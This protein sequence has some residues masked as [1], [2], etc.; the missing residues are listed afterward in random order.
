MKTDGVVNSATL[1]CELS[2][3]LTFVAASTGFEAFDFYATDEGR[4]GRR[5]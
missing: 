4:W 5:A 1:N 3:M 2:K